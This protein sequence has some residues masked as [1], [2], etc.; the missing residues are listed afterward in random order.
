MIRNGM[1]SGFEMRA[2]R[3]SIASIVDSSFDRVSYRSIGERK[4]N[5]RKTMWSDRT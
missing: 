1:E 5:D 3:E 4:F 2:E